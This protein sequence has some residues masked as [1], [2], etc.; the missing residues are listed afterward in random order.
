MT[1]TPYDTGARLQPMPWHT[2]PL[3]LP[4]PKELDRYGRV[5]F[6]TDEGSTVA[7]VYAERTDDGYTLHVGNTSGDVA[8]CG[9]DSIPH[10]DTPT[11]LLQERVAAVI[12]G[13]RTAIEQEEAEVYWNKHQALVL[14]GGEKGVRKQKLFHV[15]ENG[16]EME[17]IVKDW[18]INA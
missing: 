18:S 7:T 1:L 12:A 8:I 2:Q 6:D 9:D 10:A 13:L 16:H 5:D 11:A 15:S 14:V 17:A 3:N 4:D